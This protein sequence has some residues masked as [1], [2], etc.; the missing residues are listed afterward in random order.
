MVLV[1]WFILDVLVHFEEADERF[2]II[3][4]GIK[5]TRAS[6]YNSLQRKQSNYMFS[7]MNM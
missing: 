2:Q 1:D 5:T 4:A 7:V 3:N 6:V